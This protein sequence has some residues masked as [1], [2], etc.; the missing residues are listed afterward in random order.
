MNK[1]QQELLEIARQLIWWQPP[2]KTIENPKRLII[3]VLE[4]STPKSVRVIFD[5]F[6]YEQII[7]TLKN[8]IPG[9]MSEKSWMFWHIYL[10]IPLSPLQKRSF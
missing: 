6:G 1:N 8:P 10:K 2:E 4:Y 7:D 9:V 5:Y 3:Q